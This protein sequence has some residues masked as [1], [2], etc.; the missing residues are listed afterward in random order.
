MLGKMLSETL[1]WDAKR[2]DME[3][4]V[5]EDIF[6]IQQDDCSISTENWGKSF[7]S[8]ANIEVALRVV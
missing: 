4:I 8:H 2:R 7:I 6:S 3:D 1:E 5:H